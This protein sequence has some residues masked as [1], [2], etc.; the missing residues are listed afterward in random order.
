MVEVIK[1][2]DKP[3]FFDALKI[4]ESPQRLAVKIFVAIGIALIASV[5]LFLWLDIFGPILVLVGFIVYSLV[6]SRRTQ[7]RNITTIT[8]LGRLAIT[9]AQIVFVP[10][11]GMAV[12]DK[13]LESKEQDHIAKK[14]QAWG[15]SD[16]YIAGFINYWK[17]K[18][19]D[20]ISLTIADRNLRLNSQFAQKKVYRGEINEKDLCQKAYD[21]CKT[22]YDETNNGMRDDTN[23]RYLGELKVRLGV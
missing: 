2:Y 16:N 13:P 10:M 4:V 3:K 20:S 18:P 19:I 14:M 17:S 6:S 1:Y 12:C 15:Y 8:P 7:T 5:V 22:M 23:D 9:V 11:V 21:L